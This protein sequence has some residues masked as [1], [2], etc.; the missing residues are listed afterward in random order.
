MEI[1][2]HNVSRNKLQKGKGGK[3]IDIA[4]QEDHVSIHGE[5]KTCE[6]KHIGEYH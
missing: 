4:T 1:R 2:T 6:N 3:K 5:Q